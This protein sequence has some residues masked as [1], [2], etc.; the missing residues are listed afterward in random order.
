[1]APRLFTGLVGEEAA[2]PIGE[3]VWGEAALRVPE[4]LRGEYSDAITGDKHVLE[5]RL[6]LAR[7]L[8]RFPV[9]LLV[10]T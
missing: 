4:E 7:L 6:P 3:R 1:V 2:A 10:R 8:G 5:E 9:A